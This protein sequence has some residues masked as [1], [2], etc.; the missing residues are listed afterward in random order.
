MT[1]QGWFSP[2]K[3]FK[4]SEQNLYFRVSKIIF[5]LVIFQYL[6]NHLTKIVHW[7]HYGIMIESSKCLEDENG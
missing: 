3:N 6:M 7:L 4:K 2:L 1:L 5:Q